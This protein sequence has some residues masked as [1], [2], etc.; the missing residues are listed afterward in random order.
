MKAP[1]LLLRVVSKRRTSLRS[2]LHDEYE[3]KAVDCGY[4]GYHVEGAD[5]GEL[6]DQLQ[7]HIDQDHPGLRLTDEQVGEIIAR[8]A[9]EP[10]QPSR[11]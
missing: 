7:I 9:Y 8:D 10:E 6:F 3:I 4:C 2:S 11:N 1:L 5:D